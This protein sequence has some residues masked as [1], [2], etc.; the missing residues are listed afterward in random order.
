MSAVLNTS[1][2]RAVEEM[3]VATLAAAPVAEAIM[4]VRERYFADAQGASAAGRTS[5]DAAAQAI[6]AAA[7]QLALAGEA[8]DRPLKWVANARHEWNGVKVPASGYGIDN[9]DN[10][11]RHTGLDPQGTYRLIGR[12]GDQVPGQQSFI[13]YADLPGLG[14]V[15]REGS[16]IVANYVHVPVPGE[17]FELSIGPEPRD[18]PRH[19]CTQGRAW[20]LIVRDALSDWSTQA[21][22]PIEI[23]RV[24]G[25]ITADLPAS[26]AVVAR[27]VEILDVISRYWLDYDNTY[28]WS[29]AVNELAVPR[30]RVF[31]AAASATYVLGEEE[32][33][34][35]TVAHGDA[36]YLGCEVT[37]PWG[38]TCEYVDATGSLNRNQARPNPDGSLTYLVAAQDP[39]IHNWLNTQ[40]LD[41]GFLTLRWQA[42]PEGAT[43]AG[44]DLVKECRVVSIV[45]GQRI[46]ADQRVT[47]DERSQ[48]L[49]ER[50]AD[51]ANRLK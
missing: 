46:L 32:A 47:A 21:P 27:T 13:L 17:G 10:V 31:G 6:A 12:P 9:P 37:D 2:Q 8:R 4:R 33:L 18:D 26:S 3:M 38:V 25:V 30:V 5:M 7:F 16:E 11:H 22:F 48:Q 50:A 44:E 36:A 19:L 23:E 43:P 39:G 45:E 35:V 29:R 15:T 49:A 24:D 51:Y 14:E 42:F 20:F 40:G 1:Y 28:L 34:L 41:R